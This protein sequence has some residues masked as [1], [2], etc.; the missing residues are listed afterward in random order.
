MQQIVEQLASMISENNWRDA[1]QLAI[2]KARASKVSGIQHILNLDDFLKYANELVTWTPQVIDD[3]RHTFDLPMQFYF[4]LEQEPVKSLQSPVRPATSTEPLTP[5][6][7]WMVEYARVWGSYLDTTESAQGIESFRIRAAVDWDEYMPPP[8]G[9]LTFNQFFARHVKPGMRPIAG[10]DDHS[11]LVSPAD[12]TFVGRWSINENS[13]ISVAEE[14]LELKGLKWSIHQLLEGST[15]A[16]R[17]KGGIFTHSYLSGTDY[18]RWHTPVQGKVVEARVIQGQVFMDMRATPE[19]V[20]GKQVN[21]VDIVDSTGFQFIQTRGLL[22][23]DSPIG[24]VACLPIGMGLVSS[25]VI[26]AEVGKTLHKGEEMGYFAFGGSDFVL[27][28]ERSS[29]VQL[30]CQPNVHYKQGTW[31]GNAYPY[32]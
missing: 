13:E 12:S 15:Y 29:N 6:S 23:I 5:L 1:F 4:I 9:Y 8:S 2:Q 27:V 25:V 16:D 3:P 31:V 26:T 10:L 18:H 20:G 17:F 7:A 24:L 11:V 19:F 30:T 21:T 32:R 14:K 28:F 22:V